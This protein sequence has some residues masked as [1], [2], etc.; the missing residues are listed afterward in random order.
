MGDKMLIA[1]LFQL[2]GHGSKY[3]TE[4]EVRGVARLMGHNDSQFWRLLKVY[5]GTGISLVRDGVEC[6]AVSLFDFAKALRNMFTL[7][8]LRGEGPTDLTASLYWAISELE[9][10]QHRG[11]C[12][13]AWK[14]GPPDLVFAKLKPIIQAWDFYD[15]HHSQVTLI[16]E[17]PRTI[18]V[19]GLSALCPSN[20]AVA[21]SWSDWLPPLVHEA[22]QVLGVHDV[23]I[24]DTGYLGL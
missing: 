2:A 20:P 3:I 18:R 14:G 16:Y 21:R 11:V 13:I 17:P 5:D 4:N 15:A 1:R 7:T 19:T 23:Q 6:D 12:T 10:H 8:K 9:R 22:E 24:K